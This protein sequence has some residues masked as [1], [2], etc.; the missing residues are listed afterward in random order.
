M[1]KIKWGALVVDG[2]NKVG[3]QVLSKNRAG[4]YMR[5]KVTPVN[6]RSSYQSISRQRLAGL[7]SSWRG[8]TEPQRA[9]WRSAVEDFKTTD[10]FGDIRIPSGFNLYQ[11]LNNNL[12]QT[13]GALL[14]SPPV[15][16]ALAK[17]REVTADVTALG[18]VKIAVGLDGL[19]NDQIVQVDAT[20]P[21]SAGKNFV[22]SEFRRIALLED[23]WGTS[24]PITAQYV[25]RFGNTFSKGMRIF[26]RVFVVHVVTGQSGVPQ[27][28]TAIIN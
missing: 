9:S 4:S 11:K 18:V 1:A 13:E 3:G 10:I 17:I 19:T 25:D 14:T 8:L 22:K 20:P 16:Q 27:I 15:P 23:S 7:A 24:Q 12:L 2:R 26:F 6:P 28:C 5:N 21:L